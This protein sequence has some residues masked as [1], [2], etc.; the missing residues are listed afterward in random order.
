MKGSGNRRRMKGEEEDEGEPDVGSPGEDILES[1]CG[2]SDPRH[3]R[4][5]Y[6]W[7][8][9]GNSSVEE[10]KGRV[11]LDNHSNSEKR[12][13][14]NEELWSHRGWDK[15]Q[16]DRNKGRWD[17]IRNL[18]WLGFQD[19]LCEDKGLE[20]IHNQS[21]GQ[22]GTWEVDE[23][24]G[25]RMRSEGVEEVDDSEEWPSFIFEITSTDL[26]LTWNDHVFTTLFVWLLCAQKSFPGTFEILGRTSDFQT[27][28]LQSDE[29]HRRRLGEYNISNRTIDKY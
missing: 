17:V 15:R 5:Q 10:D 7:R 12:D 27:V 11:C 14:E 19:I 20:R 26:I 28:D 1:S 25:G 8:C 16:V 13:Q 29:Q 2:W 18:V 22:D 24:E 23:E 21:D 3:D 6:N 4:V 9:I